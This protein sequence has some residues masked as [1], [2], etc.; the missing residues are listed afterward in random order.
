MSTH[1]TDGMGAVLHVLRKHLPGAYPSGFIIAL[2]F[3]V[4]LKLPNTPILSKLP[5]V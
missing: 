5:T 4:V 2:H 1:Q 3:R